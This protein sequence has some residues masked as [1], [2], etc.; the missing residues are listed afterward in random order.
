MN[1]YVCPDDGTL[2]QAPEYT[3][4]REIKCTKCG[5]VLKPEDK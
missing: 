1:A 4:G 2:V 3:D 5:K